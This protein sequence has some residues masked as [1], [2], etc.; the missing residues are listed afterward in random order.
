[1]QTFV[2]PLAKGLGPLAGII[3][4]RS[5]HNPSVV[6]TSDKLLSTMLIEKP[7]LQ[8]SNPGILWAASPR[9]QPPAVFWA[10]TRAVFDFG[11][12]FKA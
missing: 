10:Q 7:Q 8:D 4:G 5:A 9:G 3:M 6:I 11:K 12:S 2:P 1:M